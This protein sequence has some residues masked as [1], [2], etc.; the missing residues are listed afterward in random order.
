MG[1]L[2]DI[3]AEKRSSIIDMS[4]LRTPKEWL[5]AFSGN[6]PTK[7]GP[8]VSTKTAMSLTA[9]YAAI[10]IISWTMA[11]LPLHV[12]RRGQNGKEKATSDPLY[13]ILHDEPNPEQTSF[14]WRSL[15]FTMQNIYGAGV[16]EIEYGTNGEILNLWP[17]PTNAITPK[18]TQSKQLFYAVQVDGRERLLA[19]WQV[20]VFPALSSSIDEWMSP[21]TQHRETIGAA[22]A[23]KDFGARTFGQGVNPSGILSGLKFPTDVSEKTIKEKYSDQYAGLENSHRLML[24]EDG[25]KFERVGLPP[26]DAQYLETRRF[27]I[28][29]IARIFNVPL[30]LLQEVSGTTSWGSGIEEL[31]IGF[32][33]YTLRPYAVQWEQEIKKKLLGD[34]PELFAEFLFDGLLRGKLSERVTAYATARQWGWMSTNDIREIENMNRIGAEGDSY[35]V[36]MNMIDAKDLGKSL[37]LKSPGG[38]EK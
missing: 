4:S 1:F 13:K 24:L 29:E 32:V 37:L 20:L 28:A 22:M 34:T 10:K 2:S 27:D 35:L 15:M 30:H 25:T 8:V 18:R 36:P 5:V 14:Q 26:E 21:I 17:I 9:V 31:N 3:I 23:A 6:L 12:Y 38:D 16:S 11:S 33:T 19:P 7:A